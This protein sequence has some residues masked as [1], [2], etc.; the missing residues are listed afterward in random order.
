MAM[1]SRTKAERD[2]SY[3]KL[4]YEKERNL[5]I[6]DCIDIVYKHRIACARNLALYDKLR[7]V[8][9]DLEGAKSTRG[10]IK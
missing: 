3:W 2:Y 4:S 7:E 8:E 5:M 6:D 1:P 10:E 9:V